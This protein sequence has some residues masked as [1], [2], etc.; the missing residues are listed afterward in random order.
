MSE[1][2]ITV[3]NPPWPPGLEPTRGGVARSTLE[4][5]GGL[6]NLSEIGRRLE[7][8]KSTLQPQTQRDGF[9]APVYEGGQEKLWLWFEVLEWHRGI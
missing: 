5:A 9:P 7:V 2:R 8:P 1:N 6:V 4:D 3:P